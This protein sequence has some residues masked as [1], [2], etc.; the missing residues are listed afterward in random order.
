MGGS[1]GVTIADLKADGKRPECRESS[2]IDVRC[3]RRSS[4]QRVRRDVGRG[5]SPHVFIVDCFSIFF[6]LRDRLKCMPD[7]ATDQVRKAG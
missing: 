5:S 2:R 7:G 3:G 4:K 6:I 1:R